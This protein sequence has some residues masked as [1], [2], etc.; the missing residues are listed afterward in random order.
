MK[1][2]SFLFISFLF[3]SSSLIGQNINVGPYLQDAEP[4]SITIM[5]ET[6]SGNE[7]VVEWGTSSSLGNSSSGIFIAGNGLS[8]IHTTMISGLEPNTKYYYRVITNNAQSDVFDFVTPPL[9]N[10]EAPVNLVSMSDMQQD[11][12]HTG[13]FEDIINNELIPFVNNRFGNDLSTDVAYVFIPGDLVATGSNYSSWES[14]FFDPAQALFQHVPVYPVAGNHEQNSE[15][16]FKYFSLPTNG[17]NQNDYLEHWYYKDYSNVRLIGLET[18]SGYRIQEQLDWLQ[19][20]LDDAS[21]NEHIDFVF[22]QLHH[23][24]HSELWIAGN[25][26][27]T[28]DIITLLEDF[29]SNCGKPSIHFF[30]HTHGYSRGQSRDHEHLMVNVAT[31]GGAID[32]WG[33]YAQQ[34]YKEFSRSDDDYG[35]VLLEVE[36]GNDPQFLLTRVSHGSY[37]DGL[38]NNEITDTIRVRANNVNP[39]KPSGL[40]PYEGAELSPDCIVFL[41]SNFSDDDNQYQG[42]VHWQVSTDV[43]FSSLIYDDWFQHE[44]WYYDEDL[45]AGNSMTEREI[46]S[47]QESTNYFWRV[48]YRDRG[49]GWSDWSDPIGFSTSLSIYS[50]NLLQNPGAE[51]GTNSWTGV[52]GSFESILSGECAGNN[53]YSGARLFAVG[54]VCDPNAY[55]EGYQDVD[56]LSYSSMIDND[57]AIVFFGGY[58]SD[59]SGDDI[60]AFHLEFYNAGDGLLGST[61][62]Y[63]SSS[64]DWEYL[65]DNIAVPSTTRKIRMVL[66][67]TRNAGTDNDS[68]FDDLFIRI[69]P[70]GNDCE[71]LSLDLE[72]DFLPIK[73][74]PN[75]TGNVFFLESSS[76][77][78]NTPFYFYDQEGRV[79]FEGIID[80]LKKEI[81]L[82]NYANG[83]YYIK[84]GDLK[85][86]KVIKSF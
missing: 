71:Q 69:K 29:S 70:I 18:N 35:F 31:A 32:N 12:Q 82:S 19:G 46:N 43:G 58:L 7:S 13:V 54:G 86:C 34:D 62:S 1:S 15:N 63:E 83:V 14:T 5:W 59:Y 36:A 56:L 11:W 3:V 84:V 72:E 81:N 21:N 49:L 37:E 23:P 42:A 17:T 44:N 60:P 40:F 39:D 52:S 28:G 74:Y 55:G 65:F 22:A 51:D 50:E 68:Y 79:L 53:S 80:S 33:E 25:T 24:H 9:P 47:L 57:S 73:I 64:P 48:R 10:S 20:I 26:D 45:E 8:R 85:E 16:Y 2:I 66:T 77:I 27:Y 76:Q 41:G 61:M 30:G 6:S 78:L 38:V 75:P 4:S 67:G